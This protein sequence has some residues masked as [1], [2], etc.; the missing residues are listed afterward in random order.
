[1]L[2]ATYRQEYRD[3]AARFTRIGKGE[4]MAKKRIAKVK[5]GAQSV[6]ASADDLLLAV[7]EH[8]GDGTKT[9]RYLVTFKEGAT[10]EGLKSLKSQSGFRVADARDFKGQALNFE[11]VGDAEAVVFP[12]IGL[13]LVGG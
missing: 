10:S 11:E 9:G 7:L 6:S 13:A 3:V 2:K 12:E 1:L 5:K 8:G 4:R